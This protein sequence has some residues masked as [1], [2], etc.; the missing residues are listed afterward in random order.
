METLNLSGSNEREEGRIKSLL[1]P[2]IRTGA[3]VDYLAV[4]G[5]WVCTLVGLVT[6]FVSV[7]SG[8]LILAL[9]I[10]A[11]YHFGGVGVREHSPFAAA[12]VLA[13]YVLDAVA[14]YK[15]I[16]LPGPLVMRTIITALLFS[17]LRATWIAARWKPESDDAA[18]PPRMSDTFVEGFR[19]TWPEWI[20]PKIRI[21]YFIFAFGLLVVGT[22]GIVM[23]ALK[24]RL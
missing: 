17:N 9:V 7:I 20:W 11:L 2:T 4:Q 10:L 13:F 24:G 15:M 16:F 12:L 19:D 23:L 22:A 21:P 14:S 6:C 18:L 3:D 5:F 8:N 1:W